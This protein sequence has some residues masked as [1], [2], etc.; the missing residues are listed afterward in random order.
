MR[1]WLNEPDIRFMVGEIRGD[2]EQTKTTWGIR[3]LPWL[4]LT[5][6]THKI[7]AAGF[8]IHQLNEKIK[9]MTDG[10]HSELP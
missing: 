7:R 4:I 8:G 1:K 10:K 6:R 9:E 5:D 2:L 3:A